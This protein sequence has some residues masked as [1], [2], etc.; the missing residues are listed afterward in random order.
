MAVQAPAPTH[1]HLKA[2]SPVARAVIAVAR[3]RRA[4]LQGR[5]RMAA[6]AAAVARSAAAA[7]AA[8]APSAAA[9]VAEE[10]A[11]VAAAVEAVVASAVEAVA[12][13]DNAI[14]QYNV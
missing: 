13:T 8:V 11:S 14:R 12:V 10:A 9:A 2:A 1:V 4:L 3:A 5:L 6:T 7:A